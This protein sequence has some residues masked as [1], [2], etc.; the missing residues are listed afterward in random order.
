METLPLG[1][2][3]VTADTSKMVAKRGRPVDRYNRSCLTT[4][5]PSMFHLELASAPLFISRLW[6]ERDQ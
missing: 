2:L 5:R 6:S 1:Q 3:E 4:T